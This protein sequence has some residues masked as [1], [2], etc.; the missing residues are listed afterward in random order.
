M[1]QMKIGDGFVTWVQLLLKSSRV[2][3]QLNG[4]K[5]PACEPTRGVK[6]GDPLS[7]LLFLLSLEPLCNL[8]RRHSEFG[9]QISSTPSLTATGVYFADDTTLISGSVDGLTRQLELVQVYCDGSGAK[10]NQSKC[11]VLSLDQNG[12]LPVVPGF[13]VLQDGESVKY[14]GVLF[15][16]H[17]TNREM[18]DMLNAR[19]H[20]AIVLWHRRA[21]TLEGRKLLASSVML[22]TL[23]HVAVHLNVDNED[24]RRWQSVINKFILRGYQ[25]DRESKIQFIPGRYLY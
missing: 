25:P 10:V 15:A 8:L 2:S 16:R 20:K 11:V 14:L 6:Q 3:L 24:I 7:P 19:L 22:S 17:N 23:W 13:S 5:Q 9:L 21:R 1:R 18:L 4:W 12:V